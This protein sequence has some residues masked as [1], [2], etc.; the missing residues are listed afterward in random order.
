MYKTNRVSV[1]IRHI[2]RLHH[3]TSLL[4][5]GL[6]LV[7][8][9]LRTS[10]TEQWWCDDLWFDA[11]PMFCGN[12]HKWSRSSAQQHSRCFM[13]AEQ[14]IRRRTFWPPCQRTP[15]R[16]RVHVHVEFI[17]FIVPMQHIS[18]GLVIQQ[19]NDIFLQVLIW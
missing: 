2:T 3:A 9:M 4:I 11:G 17:Y 6:W 5:Y 18:L 13:E 12:V 1:S 7:R 10:A 8:L 19:G 14:C 16:V 15:L